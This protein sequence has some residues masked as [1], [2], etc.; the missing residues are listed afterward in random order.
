MTYKRLTR[1]DYER[2]TGIA[3]GK[4]KIKSPRQERKWGEKVKKVASL[5]WI[6]CQGK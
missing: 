1:K 3:N 6:C 4:E 2:L 5:F